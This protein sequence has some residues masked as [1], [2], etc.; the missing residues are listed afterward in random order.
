MNKNP[1]KIKEMFDSIAEKYD[2]NNNIISFGLHKI[3]K[4][5][6]INGFDLKGKCLDLCTGTG[7]IAYLLKNKGLEVIGFDFSEKMLEIARKK[8]PEIEF[9]QGDCTQLPF[10]DNSFDTVT[11]SFGLRNI[12]NYDK[13]LDE[14][15]RVLKPSG[16]FL[17]LDLAKKNFL[18]NLVFDN[19][20]PV[21]INVFY[22]DKIPYEYLV[23][24]KKL[25]FDEKSL[26]NLFEKHQLELIEVKDFLFGAISCQFCK[27]KKD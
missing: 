16:K 18:A 27:N 20:I 21:L 19:V 23:K 15:K 8:H 26:I 25:F 9:I 6:A 3:V 4:K 22:K 14:I 10:A 7:D 1:Q 12:E 2:F 13:A 11:I 5:L 24:S 17:H